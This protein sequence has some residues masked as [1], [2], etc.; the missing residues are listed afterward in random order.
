LGK[1]FERGARVEAREG[2][3]N[4]GEKNWRE[5]IY[6]NLPCGN[7]IVCFSRVL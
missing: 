6:K 5:N 1:G 2:R 7:Q 3:K 4:G